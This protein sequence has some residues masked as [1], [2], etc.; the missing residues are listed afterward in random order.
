MKR[1]SVRPFVC[2]IDRQQQR[3]AAGLLLSAVRAGDLDQQQ[4]RRSATNAGSVTLTAE[5]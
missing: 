1:S 3:H 5:A 2:P 4:A